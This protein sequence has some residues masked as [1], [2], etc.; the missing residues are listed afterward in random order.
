MKNIYHGK[1]RIVVKHTYSVTNL[2]HFTNMLVDIFYLRKV[3]HYSS[4]DMT[5]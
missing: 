2:C 4:H 3:Q 1:T 5:A